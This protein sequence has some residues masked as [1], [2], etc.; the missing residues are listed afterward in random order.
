MRTLNCCVPGFVLLATTAA[1]AWAEDLAAVTRPG[2]NI[3]RT[4]TLLDEAT[5]SRHNTVRVLFYGQS[6]T[7]GQWSKIVAEDLKKRYPNAD[8]VI[9]NHAIG[10]FSAPALIHTC[11]YDL[12]PHYPDLLIFHVYDNPGLVKFDEIIRRVRSRTTAEI[13]L[14]THHDVGRKT[15]YE[16]S[17]SIRQIAVKYQ[18]GLVDIERHWKETLAKAGTTPQDYLADSVHHNQKGAELYAQL[19]NAFLVRNPALSNELGCGWIKE[20]PASD[21]GA[22]KRLPDGSLE[23]PFSGNR[24]DVSALPAAGAGPL[25]DVLID[26]RKPS[27]YPEAYTPTRPSSAPFVWW[28]A[29][30]ILGHEQPL[31]AE[32]WTL[33]VIESTPDG[34]TFR[35]RATGSVTGYDGEGTNTARFVSKSGRVVISPEDGNWMV[36]GAL[37]Y[38][39]KKKPV[40]MPTDFPVTWQVVPRF[41]DRL[42]FAAAESAGVERSVTLIQGVANGPHTLRLVPAAGGTLKLKGFRVYRPP[43]AQ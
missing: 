6:I 27:T 10:G 24:I 29:F 39:S 36:A 43:L 37:E 34:K 7:A 42:E 26:G 14:A 22:V 31:V 40:Q 9:E 8:L 4:M 2:A 11:E 3:Q 13:L 18:C 23:L 5:P 38:C 17:E 15:D 41:V 19:V 20:I 21:A 12:Y 32:D 35:F 30:K 1:W 33:R 25:A 28:P 16:G